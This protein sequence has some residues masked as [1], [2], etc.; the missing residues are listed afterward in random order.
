MADASAVAVV[1]MSGRFPGAGDLAGYWR[2][3]R[4]GVCSITDFTEAELAAAGV[5]PGLAGHPAYV[6]AKGF[7]PEADRF[8]AE[9]FGFGRTEAAVLDPQHRLLLETAWGALEDAGYDPYHAPGRTG[10][11]VGGSTSEH[12]IAAH[13]DPR[14]TA[15]LGPLHTRML[16]DRDFLAPWISYRLGL[17][18][19]SMTVQTACSTSLTAVHVAVQALL[20]DECD[21]ALAGGVAVDTVAKRGYLYQSGGI[22]SPDGRCRPFD[23]AAAGTVGG[24]GVGLVVLRRLADALA[25]GD[26]IRAVVLGSAVT[27]DGAIK[28]GFTSPGVDQQTRAI[29][30]AWAVAGLDPT[31]AQYLEAH[32]TGTSVGD[33][34]ELA[35]ANAAFGGPTRCVIGSVKSNIGHLDSAAGVAGLIKVVL[36]L[37]H[38]TM[39]PTANI[40]RPHAD[41]DATSLR[42]L[43]HAEPWQRPEAG[44]RL[45][46][47][48]SLGIGGTNVHIV[49]AEAPEAE[50][51]APAGCADPA[52]PAP[53][54]LPIS[55][56]TD[57][58]LADVAAR[59]AATLRGPDAPALV[60][61]A[62]T[63][64]TGRAALAARACVLA[65]SAAEAAT[66]LDAVAA[67]GDRL[68]AASDAPAADRSLAERWVR[69]DDVSWPALP[70]R[71]VHLPTYPF[72]GDAYGEL[73]LATAGAAPPI[74]PGHQTDHDAH[75]E[76]GEH[77]A[78]DAH[79]A[80]AGP[81]DPIETAVTKMFMAALELTDEAALTK[82][83]FAA[84]GDSLTAVHL[85]GELR[86]KLGL[87]VP[88][89]LF[90]EELPVRDI[91]AAVLAPPDD[92][93][94]QSLLDDV[95]N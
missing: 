13:A 49:V 95:D 33:R 65:R 52:V 46:G 22:L 11:Y 34:I 82:T 93:L 38:R 91:I 20:L 60:D 66:A 80:P 3:L 15:R 87:D 81:D 71:R 41:L 63:L 69:G 90:L 54:A 1:G 45:A 14:L 37:G 25:D 68:G 73:S 16:T 84:G 56:R 17:T 8:E 64:R 55:A 39:A 7:L 21:T 28:V 89:K 59:L 19:P 92:T 2:N 50:R 18:G 4:D 79:G 27:N 53:L 12:M 48:S 72:A 31:A 75:G 32:G 44:S 74:E 35:A 83:Y 70:G 26:P 61:A 85:V 58:Q 88:I 9:L 10:V 78:D 76:H 24:N 6:R 57:A 40:T 23:A 67:G 36:M 62:A 94:L 30:E 51:A 43:T 5:D 42:L 86:D 77:G 29:R 47:I